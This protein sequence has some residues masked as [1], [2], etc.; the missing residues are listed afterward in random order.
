MDY[1]NWNIPGWSSADLLPVFKSI[2][3]DETASGSEEFHGLGGEW[4]MDH[5]RY[6]N[7]LSKRFLEV[8]SAVGLV[9]NDDF[10]LWSRPQ[11]GVGRFHVSQKNGSRCSGASAFLHNAIKR[12]GL[13]V[14]S[15]ALVRRIVFDSTKT[16]TGVVYNMD[17]DTME[18][19]EAHLKPGGEVLMTAGAIG[20]PQIL[21]C[22][23]IGPARHLRALG[24]PII[25][26]NPHVGDNLQDQP[27]AVVSF[28]TPKAGVSM[29]SK[30]RLFGKP[31]P[32]P[33]LL[34]LI[35]KKGLLTSV[36]CDHGAFVRVTPGVLQP[37]LQFRFIP[38][39]ALV[40]DDLTGF[41]KTRS[42]GRVK[43]GYSIESV[44]VRA[45]SKGRVR[46]ASSNSHIRPIIDMGYLSN[47]D[48]LAT[49]RE[50]I[51]LARFL[52]RHPE[53]GEYLGEEVYPGPEVQ[54]DQQIEEYIRNTVHSSSGLVGTCKMGVEDD[55][56]VGPDLKLL[57]VKG[58]RVADS[59]AIPVL[60]GGQTATPTVMIAER[61]AQLIKNQLTLLQLK[62]SVDTRYSL[63]SISSLE[64]T[65]SELVTPT[66]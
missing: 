35:W 4:S 1:D 23:G 49:L 18:S 44:A 7:P 43:D 6:Q 45:K 28:Q 17:D 3:N 34:W 48:D 40:P 66:V 29:T 55:A 39:K 41:A 11:D 47:N 12:S 50:G 22:S 36:G 62:S 63:E 5:V 54:T 15:G 8:S 20:S 37:D 42:H 30:L 9:P 57:G 13:T 46:L 26:D 65:S 53:W 19:F 58:V 2:E 61:A 10:N 16:A 32:F 51:K 24:I 21:M 31:N 59:S 38:S 64:R 56:V 14:R 52:C 33:M 27:A 25:H 60:P